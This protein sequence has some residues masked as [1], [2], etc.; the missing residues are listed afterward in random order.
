[1]F[2]KTLLLFTYYNENRDWCIIFTFTPFLRFSVQLYK[3]IPLL[4]LWRPAFLWLFCCVFRKVFLF[5]LLLV[6]SHV[7]LTGRPERW[8]GKRGGG[9]FSKDTFTDKCYAYF[10]AWDLEHLWFWRSSVF[11]LSH[12]TGYMHKL[13]RTS[14]YKKHLYIPI[15]TLLAKYL[16][17]PI[18]VY[19]G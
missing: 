12:D 16:F 14:V 2:Q 15:G 18:G 6:L 7:S 17:K 10:D 1:M 9:W 5:V 13:G 19:K 8:Q 4:F 3:I 11:A